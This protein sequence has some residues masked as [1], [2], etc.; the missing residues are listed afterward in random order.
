M[1]IPLFLSVGKTTL[2]ITRKAAGSYTH[3]RWADGE[4]TTFTIT[5][6]VQ[7]TVT[8]SMT[9]LLPEGDR[10]KKSL[11]LF[12]ATIAS[13]IRTALEG[14]LLPADSFTWTDGYSYEIRE[15]LPYRCGVL[16]HDMA[17]A[18]RKEVA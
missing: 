3:G 14:V 11:V 17:I 15:V 9:K 2:T 12:N 8:P 16:D 13:P 6:N 5:A 4:A 10:S 1:T 18:V 7:P